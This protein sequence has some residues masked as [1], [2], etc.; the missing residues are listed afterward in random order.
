AEAGNMK[1]EDRVRTLVSFRDIVKLLN[2][3]LK[4][5]R[6]EEVVQNQR[7]KQLQLIKGFSSS[8][9]NLLF[10]FCLA[11][12]DGDSLNARLYLRH[13]YYLLGLH[14]RL[15]LLLSV[16]VNETSLKEDKDIRRLLTML[17]VITEPNNIDVYFDPNNGGFTRKYSKYLEELQK[18]TP[19]S[20]ATVTRKEEN[21]AT[22]RTNQP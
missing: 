13:A 12:L 15:T 16:I 8:I 4:D 17:A 9:R 5:A 22:S 19:A 14:R 2:K 20:Q 6:I 1:G 21:Q 10:D 11:A 3:F 7:Y 18:L